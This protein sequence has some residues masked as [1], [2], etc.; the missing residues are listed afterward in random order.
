LINIFF[1]A[2]GY[3]SRQFLGRIFEI[4][5]FWHIIILQVE[6]VKHALINMSFLPFIN[7]P[8]KE[9][10]IADVLAMLLK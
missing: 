8:S 6:L 9:P 4:P 1:E 10:V 2:L 5:T 3:I 7:H